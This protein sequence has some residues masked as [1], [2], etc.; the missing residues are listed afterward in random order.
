MAEQIATAPAVHRVLA[1]PGSGKTRL[2]TEEIQRQL[3]GGLP[4][5]SILGI[6]FT[7]RAARELQ[8]RLR[9]P[10]APWVGTFH[11]L[12]RRVQVDLHR[13]PA[14]INLD[15]LIPDATELLESGMVPAWITRLRLIAV[16]EAQDLDP[17]QVDFLLVLRRHNHATLFLVGD[18]DQAIYGFRQASARYLLEAGR[19]FSQPVQTRMLNRNHRSAQAIVGLAQEILAH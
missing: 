4:A 17:T 13:L 16:D 14:S 2:L 18:P 1:G 10:T 9:V 6:T 8:S 15:R 5:P 3:T 12:A 7:K 11:Q 19:Y